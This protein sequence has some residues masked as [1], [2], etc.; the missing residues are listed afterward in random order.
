MRGGPG[1]GDSRL[2]VGRSIGARTIR[3]GDGARTG[4]D[5]VSGAAVATQATQQIM[6]LIVFGACA[7]VSAG[8]GALVSWQGAAPG[9]DADAPTEPSSKTARAPITVRMD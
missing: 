8:E 3:S 9:E 7:G 2:P 6:G 1:S 5:E 4:R